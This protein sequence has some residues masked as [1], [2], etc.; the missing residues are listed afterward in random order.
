MDYLLIISLV[1]GALVILAVM[2]EV[3]IRLTRVESEEKRKEREKD[4]AAYK[5]WEDDE[6]RS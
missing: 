4:K 5:K 3:V 6:R 2:L 1:V